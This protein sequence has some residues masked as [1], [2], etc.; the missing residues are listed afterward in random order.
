MGKIV[1]PFD[2]NMDG[3]VDGQDF[4]LFDIFFGDDEEKDPSREEEHQTDDEDEE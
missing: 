1:D 4:M 3:K 2:L